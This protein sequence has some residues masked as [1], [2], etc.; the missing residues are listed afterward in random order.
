MDIKNRLHNNSYKLNLETKSDIK[1][2]NPSEYE[3]IFLNPLESMIKNIINN[4][5]KIVREDILLGEINLKQPGSNFS[6]II[7]NNQPFDSHLNKNKNIQVAEDISNNGIIVN[8][9]LKSFKIKMTNQKRKNLV[10]NNLC[11]TFK[12]KFN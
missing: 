7:A 8:N 10:R 11:I 1:P 3:L 12:I 9:M 6:P 5:I 2:K 4:R